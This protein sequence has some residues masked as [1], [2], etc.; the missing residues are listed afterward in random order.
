MFNRV[1]R[2]EY[3]LKQFVHYST[4]LGQIRIGRRASVI[5]LLF[6]FAL[7]KF[8]CDIRSF[9]F[10][11]KIDRIFIVCYL[12]NKEV[13]VKKIALLFLVI[14][15]LISCGNLNIETIPEIASIERIQEGIIVDTGETFLG[16]IKGIVIVWKKPVNFALE[17]ASDCWFTYSSSQEE[18]KKLSGLK[19]HRVRIVFVYEDERPMNF[20]GKQI[21]VPIVRITG[22]TDLGAA[23][24]RE[25]SRSFCF[26][27]LFFLNLTSI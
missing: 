14:C 3:R 6:D 24:D 22:I 1:K 13:K 11:V 2:S 20:Q 9:L 8:N 25:Q 23:E 26:F 15:F 4:S 5:K 19:E 16:S 21:H 18:L 10:S 7:W 27:N 17:A 12:R